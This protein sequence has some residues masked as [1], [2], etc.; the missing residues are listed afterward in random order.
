MR[1]VWHVWESGEVYSCFRCENLK[2]TTWNTSAYMGGN[3]KM[4]L[5]EM[6][7]GSMDWIGLAQDKDKWR[8]LVNAVMNLRIP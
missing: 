2:K 7:W 6:E 8:A 4:Y 5:Q 1:A 3:N